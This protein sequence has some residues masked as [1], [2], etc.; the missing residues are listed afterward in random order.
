MRKVEAVL[1]R[2]SVVLVGELGCVGEATPWI[3]LHRRD[4][5]AVRQVPAKFADRCLFQDFVVEARPR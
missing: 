4:D 5:P 2:A 1:V 3:L